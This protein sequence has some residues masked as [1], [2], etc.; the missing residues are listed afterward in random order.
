SRRT[1][2]QLIPWSDSYRSASCRQAVRKASRSS[3][4]F[5][6]RWTVLYEGKPGGSISQ[7]MPLTRTYSRAWKH[8]RLPLGGRPLPHQIT[9]GRID[10][11][12]VQI[13]SGTP[14]AISFSSIGWSPGGLAGCRQDNQLQRFCPVVLIFPELINKKM[15]R[16]DEPFEHE[17]DVS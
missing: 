10:S 12:T 15:P 9:G 13:S 17:D 4:R 5:H 3:H 6:R 1:W 14:R 7:G 11:K 8:S 2:S 16:I